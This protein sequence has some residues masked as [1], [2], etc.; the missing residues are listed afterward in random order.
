VETPVDIERD[1]VEARVV[2]GA[3]LETPVVQIGGPRTQ[4]EVEERRRPLTVGLTLGFALRRQRGDRDTGRNRDNPRIVFGLP[5]C[6]AVAPKDVG[7]V[8]RTSR[9]ARME[10]EA[11]R[12]KARTLERVLGVR[13]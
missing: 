9:D 2:S 5:A 13:H 8:S 4:P 1:V 7:V 3:I 11:P 6:L 10:F 12:T